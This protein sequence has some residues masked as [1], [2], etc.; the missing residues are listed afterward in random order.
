[1]FVIIPSF[2]KARGLRLIQLHE[3]ISKAIGVRL[4]W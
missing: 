3:I 1:M 2:T 4:K